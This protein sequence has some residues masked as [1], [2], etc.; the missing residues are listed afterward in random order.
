[1]STLAF[2]AL[3]PDGGSHSLTIIFYPMA[4]LYRK[5]YMNSP[6]QRGATTLPWSA[7]FESGRD[8]TREGA[9]PANRVPRVAPL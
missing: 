4:L 8:L 1:M 9:T 7:R 3:G 6:R 2:D 5:F